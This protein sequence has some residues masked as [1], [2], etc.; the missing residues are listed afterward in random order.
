MPYKDYQCLASQA[1]LLNE[2]YKKLE[3]LKPMLYFTSK[4][5]NGEKIK[6]CQTLLSYSQLTIVARA[7]NTQTQ[8]DI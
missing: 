3:Y 5:L 7:K 2:T 1:T 6:I 8:V 4:Y